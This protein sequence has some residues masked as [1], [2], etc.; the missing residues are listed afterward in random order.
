MVTCLLASC[1][2]TP[3]PDLRVP[4]PEQWQQAPVD[5]PR[6]GIASDSGSWWEPFGDE[7]LNAL[8][9]E[10]RTA[11]L[12]LGQAQARLRAARALNAHAGD[13][14]RP[15]LHF[16]TSDPI[17]PDASASFFVAGFD[18]VWELGLF[19]RGTAIH[20]LA[21]ADL[22][23]AGADLRGAQVV[24]AAEVASDWIELRAAQTREAIL[25]RIRDLRT[26]QAN[27]VATRA[28]LRIATPQQA[29]QADVAAAEAEAALAEPRAAALAAAQALA[30]LLGRSEPDPT[31]M[32][33]GTLPQLDAWRLKQV[34]ADLLRARPDIIRGEAAVLR[35]AGELGIAK[36]DLYPHIAF[37]GSLLWSTSEI[38]QRNTNTNAIASLG[39][40]IDIPLFDWGMRRAQ[41]TAKGEDLQASVLAYRKTV[42]AAVAEVETALGALEQQRLREQAQVRAWK[43]NGELVDK[44][45]Q[46]R[47]LR[48]ASGLDDAA[49][50]ADQEQAALALAETRATRALDYVALYKALGGSSPI[51]APGAVD[52]PR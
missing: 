33:P 40:S 38:E 17:D 13:P 44:I 35:A 50:R 48:L 31:W 15:N 41:A 11:N 19:G 20:R 3:L 5:V 45:T 1:V 39:P 37:G 18:S 52:D 42:L 36:A 4:L 28:R 32:V 29:V 24:V 6:S 7:R 16:H 47:R 9:E 43:L 46:R 27:F 51:D 34:P 25:L 22:D 12:D 30:V 26:R 10:A 14:L 8:E 23:S 2:S 49:S 21:R